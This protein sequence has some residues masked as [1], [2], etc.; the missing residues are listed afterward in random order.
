[1][2]PGGALLI[3]FAMAY[4]VFVMKLKQGALTHHHVQ[5]LLRD[6]KDLEPQPQLKDIVKVLQENS[7]KSKCPMS[8]INTAVMLA[9]KT[10]RD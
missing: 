5:C 8:V 7:A 3:G 6:P 1:M 9:H 2:H 4:G 10:K